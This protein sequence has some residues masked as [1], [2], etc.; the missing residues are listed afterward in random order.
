MK[1]LACVSLLVV[2]ACLLFAG[3]SEGE[4][5]YKNN[6]SYSYQ[7]DSRSDDY[8]DYGFFSWCWKTAKDMWKGD[9]FDKTIVIC[10]ILFVISVLFFIAWGIFIAFDSWFLPI[11][12]APGVIIKKDYTPPSMTPITST[13]NNVTTTT[14]IQNPEV[15]SLL[16]AVGNESGWLSVS[17]DY[18]H[19]VSRGRKVTA[20]YVRGRYSKDMYLKEI[21]DKEA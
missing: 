21:W 19:E 11:Q 8:D 4:D 16:I 3:C 20:G 12:K 7:V 15:H 1:K 17:H 14:Y 13:V 2:L 10:A 6:G 18:Y 9:W 5:E